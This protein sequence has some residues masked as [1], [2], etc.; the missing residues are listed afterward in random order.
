[1]RSAN[2]VLERQ[3]THQTSSWCLPAH[4]LTTTRT[5]SCTLHSQFGMPTVGVMDDTTFREILNAVTAESDADPTRIDFANATRD[6]A[7]VVFC[8]ALHFVHVHTCTY[9]R[10]DTTHNTHARTHH[11]E[12]HTH[13]H[14]HRPRTPTCTARSHRCGYMVHTHERTHARTEHASKSCWICCARVSIRQ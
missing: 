6:I 12:A 13:T 10:S 9:A 2:A 5:S 3:S 1:M 4:H 11:T 7:K 14:A 8:A